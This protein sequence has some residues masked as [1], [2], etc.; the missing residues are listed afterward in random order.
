[1]TILAALRSFLFVIL[2]SLCFLMPA[3]KRNVAL[4][5]RLDAAGDFFIWLQSGAADI[6]RFARESQRRS[7]LIANRAWADYARYTGLWDEVID[8]EPVQLMRKPLYRLRFLRRVRSLGASLLI[9][10]RAARVFLQEDEIARVSGATVSIANAGTFLNADAFRGWLGDRCYVRTIAV[11]Q[12][13]RVHETA[14]NQE[15]ALALTGQCATQFDLSA[16]HPT[17]VGK[18]VVV[19]VGAGQIGRVWPMENY[20]ELIKYLKER[21]PSIDVVL[22][23]APAD[24]LLAER[25]EAILPG[26]VRNEVGKTSLREFVDVIAKSQLVICNDSS[27]FHIAM[28]LKKKVLCFLGGGH[29]GWFAPYPEGF[30][31]AS[32]AKVLSVSMNCFWCDWRCKF[33]RGSGGAYRCVASIPIALAIES[34]ESLGIGS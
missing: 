25:L 31:G 21:D 10:P 16:L 17:R 20:A 34:L 9:Q 30:S 28:S 3:S 5:V 22:L 6:A 29:H 24:A 12:D 32:T 8:V 19:A 4:T 18:I 13:R 11:S 23:G 26:Q 1:M 14:R 7:V 33:P 27:A 15:F 2:D